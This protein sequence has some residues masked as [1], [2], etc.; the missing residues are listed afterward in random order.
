VEADGSVERGG[1]VERPAACEAWGRGG[2][3]GVAVD[4]GGTV[5]RPAAACEA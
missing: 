2:E 4:L 3:A 5:E 1:T